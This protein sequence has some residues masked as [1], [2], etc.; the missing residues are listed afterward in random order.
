[1][2]RDFLKIKPKYTMKLNQNILL[3]IIKWWYLDVF[4]SREIMEWWIKVVKLWYITRGFVWTIGHIKAIRLHTTRYIC[5]H[6]LM[7]P[8]SNFKLDKRGLPI[9]LEPLFYRLEDNSYRS[10]SFVL[11]LLSISRCLPGLKEPDLKTIVDPWRGK[12]PEGL[13]EF[14][15]LFIHQNNLERYEPTS[16][17]LLDLVHSIKAGPLGLATQTSI[18]QTYEV[19]KKLKCEI[20]NLTGG[21]PQSFTVNGRLFQPENKLMKVINSWKFLALRYKNVLIKNLAPTNRLHL[22]KFLR[23]LSIVNDPEA[24]ARIICIFDYFSQTA[25]KGLHDWALIQL[26]KIPSDRT[27]TQDPRNLKGSGPY[28][29]IDLTAA[30]DRFPI[31]IQELLL[32]NLTGTLYARS[33]TSI[34]TKC[35]VYVPWTDTTVT[36]NCGQPMGAYSSWAIFSLS[37]HLIVQYAAFRLGK[38]NFENYILLGDDIVISDEDVALEYMRLLKVMDV[39]ISDSKTHISDNCYEFAKRWIYKGV[40]ISP[41]PLRGLRSSW[42]DYHLFVPLIYSIIYRIPPQRFTTVPALFGD[43]LSFNKFFK[44]HINNLVKQAE[45]FSAVWRFVK[46]GN[47]NLIFELI[48]RYD[49]QLHPFPSYHSPESKEYF[50][51]LFER[52]LLGEIFSHL[53]GIQAFK[54]KLLKEADRVSNRGNSIEQISDEDFFS[55]QAA[56]GYHPV[57]ISVSTEISENE[58]RLSQLIKSKEWVKIL[59]IVTLTDPSELLLDKKRREKSSQSVA[60]FAKNLFKTAEM[61]RKKDTWFLDQF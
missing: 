42:K 43:L 32:E 33:W 56:M 1:M 50:D 20:T 45:K 16:F 3:W 6:P 11:T 61:Q 26:K 29:S 55:F 51:W 38:T 44:K 8:Q 40:E 30:T 52:T 17:T 41:I 2:S 21:E 57:I 5:G 19:W 53:E 24:K 23:R 60:K 7:T 12:V 10:K 18:L 13:I 48:Q 4:N 28:Y 58:E 25:L 31:V 34:L 54:S 27:F 46:D 15:P 47:E 22:V 59:Q 35:Q 36:Y 14:I 39:G 9:G 37:H 49:T